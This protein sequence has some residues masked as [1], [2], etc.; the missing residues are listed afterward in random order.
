MLLNASLDSQQANPSLNPLHKAEQPPHNLDARIFCARS[1]YKLS[2]QAGS[3]LPIIKGGAIRQIADF[4]DIENLKLL[5][6]CAATLAN[7]TTDSKAL[8]AF[9]EFDGIQALLEL[10]WLPCLHVKILCVTALCRISQHRGHAQLLLRSKV[11]IE[12]LSMLTLPHDELQTLAVSCIMNLIFH[13]HFFPERVFVGEPHAVQNQLGIMSVVSQLATTSSSTQFAVEVLFNLSLYRV[14]CYGA[15]HGSGAELLH[16]IAA[17][18]CKAIDE[19]GN[20]SSRYMAPMNFPVRN[21]FPVWATDSKIVMRLLHLMAET[22]SNFSAYMEFHGILSSYGMKTLTLLLFSALRDVGSK[23]YGSIAEERLRNIAVPCSRALANFSSNE[24]LRKNAFLQEIVHMTTRLTLLDRQRFMSSPEDSRVLLRNI[25]RTLCNLSFNDTCTAY[26]M[27]FPQVLPLLHAFVISVDE[28][29]ATPPRE[30]PAT[31]FSHG[32]LFADEDVREDALV[33]ILNLAQQAA[34]SSD[35]VRILDG[36]RLAIAA[37]DPNN[38]GHL[39]Y[40]YSLVLCNLLFESRLQ[41]IVYGDQVV[42]SLI[43]GFYFFGQTET[44]DDAN[45]VGNAEQVRYTNLKLAFGDDQERFLAAIC[46]MASEIMDARNIERIAFC[47][48]TL[49]HI[50][51]SGHVNQ[52]II[53]ALIHC[54]NAN[55]ETLSLLAC[56]ASFAIVSFT[57]EGRHQLIACDHLA[58]ALNCLGRTSQPE[59]QQYAAIAAC[60]VSTL[61]CIWT[62]AELKDFIVMALLRANS[63]QAKQI[64]AKTLSNLL[65][66]LST[67]EK[68]VEDG[69]LYALMKLSQVML[70]RSTSALHSG[71]SGSSTPVTSTRVQNNPNT[72]RHLQEAAKTHASGNSVDEM[73]SIGLQALFNL[74]CEHQYHQRLLNNGIMPYLTAAVDGKQASV[75]AGSS[76]GT[77]APTLQTHSH[78]LTASSFSFTHSNYTQLQFSLSVDSRRYAMGIICNLSSYEEN[79]KELMNA[80]VT[81]IIRKYVD[82]D[83]ETRASAAMALR[84]ISCKQ[85][86]V[87]MLCERKTLCLLISFTQCEHQIVKQFAVEALA[88]CSLITDS[89]HLYGELRVPRA[90]LALLE[91]VSKMM[92]DESDDNDGGGGGDEESSMETC[93]AAL[94]CLHNIALDDALA[95]HLLEESSIVRFLPLLER[96]SLGHDAHACLLVATMAHILAGKP[97]CGEALLRQRVVNLCAHLHRQHPHNKGI[98]YECVGILM[99]L[100][101]Y[102]QIQEKL[103]ETQ[104]I[105]VVASICSS[106]SAGADLRIRECGAITIRN[107]TLSVTEHLSLFYGDAGLEGAEGEELEAKLMEQTSARKGLQNLWDELDGGE[108]D[109]VTVSRLTERHLLHGV[110]YFQ[111][112]LDSLHDSDNA[113]PHH[114]AVPA[115]DRILHEACAGIANLS[116]IKAFRVMMVR[117]GIVNTLLRVYEHGSRSHAHARSSLLKSICAA[118][119]HR[120]AVEEEATIDDNGLLVPSLLSILRLSDEELHHVRYECEK[121]SLFSP[122]SPSLNKTLNRR[123]SIVVVGGT[124]SPAAGLTHIAMAATTHCV[125]Q[126]YRDQKWMFFVLKTTLSSASMIPQLEKKHMH[127]IGIPRLSFQDILTAAAACNNAGNCSTGLHSTTSSATK[128]TTPVFGPTASLLI[129]STDADTGFKLACA[130]KPKGGYL[131]PVNRDKYM[132]HHDEYTGQPT[133]TPLHIDK[134]ALSAD[135]DSTTTDVPTS[136]HP[137]RATP[138]WEMIMHSRKFDRH[139]RITRRNHRR[140]PNSL[141]ALSMLS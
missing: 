55:E 117:L 41:Q 93:M 136:I 27:E 56:A 21:T 38:S 60:N 132:I 47:A 39:K 72:P 64:H 25:V 83:I 80:Q 108:D 36:K 96:P 111:Q 51:A 110:K 97:K 48:A 127:T 106:P 31:G 92:S 2:C 58:K 82:Q 107:L 4:S 109:G 1:L 131:L 90:V 134:N 44:D 133:L 35:L 66:H 87:E 32:N 98:A 125:K 6:Y 102:Q 37:Q 7:L 18:V 129:N 17:L 81:D 140:N 24:D 20:S 49:Y 62:S 138:D 52:R 112:E 68:V 28:S 69:V 63:V 33:T 85:P 11:I 16:S 45:T 19:T 77:S 10:S 105:H 67:R 114:A 91:C 122:N 88:N 34:Y 118:T 61:E 76:T 13:G 30:G 79:H 53:Q 26:F 123:G 137:Q 57:A 65:S 15:L 130:A 5:R 75:A 8:D 40:V 141:P 101:T 70:Y 3:E 59:S 12:M 115:S 104:A 73:F 42:L 135:G 94:K 43:Y 46:I 86:W 50:C 23:L 116:T 113:S 84:N 128:A 119:L 121:V 71:H 14:S 120:L 99:N 103:T 22:L 54:C 74:S 89:L 9:V 139:M 124:T 29:Q 95:L 100:S 78:L 126:S